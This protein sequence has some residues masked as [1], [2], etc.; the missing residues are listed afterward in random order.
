MSGSSSQFNRRAH[1]DTHVTLSFDADIN[2][3]LLYVGA[4]CDLELELEGSAGATQTYKAVPAGTWISLP[5]KQIKDAG[6]TVA[7]TEFVGHR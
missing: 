5:I 6:T 7:I 2:I 1:P 3:T 4:D